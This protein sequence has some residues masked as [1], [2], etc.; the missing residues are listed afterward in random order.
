MMRFVFRFWNC[1][2]AAGAFRM[3]RRTDDASGTWRTGVPALFLLASVARAPGRRAP[4]GVDPVT[5]QPSRTVLIVTHTTDFDTVPSPPP[6]PPSRPIGAGGRMFTVR[7]PRRIG[8]RAPDNTG[9][10]EGVD[11]VPSPTPPAT[12]GCRISMGSSGWV[13]AGGGVLART[14]PRTRT[15]KRAALHRLCS[16]VNSRHTATR[17]PLTSSSDNPTHLATMGLGRA[18]RFST[19]F[20]TSPRT[21]AA[22]YAVLLDRAPG[23][24]PSGRS[25]RADMRFRGRAAGAGA[26]STRA[27][28]PQEVWGMRD[29]APTCRA[30]SDGF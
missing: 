15:A 17:R 18:F 27:R 28:P 2:G 21:T 25:S 23:R 3:P 22:R 20:T 1:W 14:A 29:S 19:R 9:R 11:A 10:A 6:N 7:V 26:C 4:T 13:K 24:W 30:E 12:G 16:A 8:C 5:S